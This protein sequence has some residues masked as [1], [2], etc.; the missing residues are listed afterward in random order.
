MRIAR[1][2]M[3]DRIKGSYLGVKLSQ[4]FGCSSRR[5]NYRTQDKYKTKKDKTKYEVNPCFA[6]PVYDS[7]ESM[8]NGTEDEFGADNVFQTLVLKDMG[9]AVEHFSLE[10]YITKASKVQKQEHKFEIQGKSDKTEYILD[11][12]REDIELKVIYEKGKD[13]RIQISNLAFIDEIT[14]EYQVDQD[15]KVKI[16]DNAGYKDKEAM[17]V[18]DVYKAF[19]LREIPNKSFKDYTYNL[20]RDAYTS[21]KPKSQKHPQLVVVGPNL[22]LEKQKEKEK[23]FPQI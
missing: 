9:S 17:T 15:G 14:L 10:D 22:V 21:E 12:G 3:D 16:V 19:L 13:T 2:L 7:L 4:V 18:L 6:K 11:F 23:I 5:S 1:N 8:F 20:N